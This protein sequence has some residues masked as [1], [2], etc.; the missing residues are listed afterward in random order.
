VGGLT[1]SDLPAGPF[2]PDG[3]I[4]FDN[5][6]I[7]YE[8]AWQ[9]PEDYDI[10]TGL[11]DPYARPGNTPG[12]P[13]QTN[14]YLAIKVLSEFRSGKFEQTIE[15]SLYYF[16]IPSGKN[17]V[18]S[19]PNQSAAEDSRLARQNEQATATRT[20]TA[21]A[22][23]STTASPVSGFTADQLRAKSTAARLSGTLL[24]P[25]SASSITNAAPAG[26]SSLPATNISN[27]PAAKAVISNGQT[28]GTASGGVL[29][30]TFTASAP[31]KIADNANRGGTQPG[32]HEY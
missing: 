11:A 31:K 20:N 16:P 2:L 23:D 25:S 22:T 29:F 24:A 12:T 4:S 18:A 9:R 15:G 5:S 30:N 8:I 10:T 26:G 14:T 27:L 3:T 28:V 7:L 21:P 13:Q 32:A 19:A 1:G 17:T 6:Q